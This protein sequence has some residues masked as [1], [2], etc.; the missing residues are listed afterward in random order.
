MKPVRVIMAA[1]AALTMLTFPVALA[2]ETTSGWC[3]SVWFP[4]S[5]EP[6]GLDSIR[7]HAELIDIVHPF[8]YSPLPDGTLQRHDGAEDIETLELLREANILVIPSI[9]ASVPT[10]LASDEAMTT[11]IEVITT[12]VE[13]MDYDGIDIDY[14]G[15]PAGNRDAFSLFV[16]RLADALHA[17]NRL[18]TIAL[19]AKTNDEGTWEGPRGQDWS[20]ILPVVDI[21]NL[22]TYDYTSRNEP[23]GPIAPSH[24]MADVVG[25]A[26][27]FTSLDRIRLGIPFY[28]YSWLRGSPP[29]TTISHRSVMRWVDSFNLD[30][31]NRHADSQELLIELR[32]TGLPRQNIVLNDAAS[33]ESKLETVIGVHAN[34]GGA[35]IWGIGGEDPAVWDILSRYHTGICALRDR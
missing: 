24:W 16:E 22:M 4:S 1:C 26:S 8:W 5:S 27:R 23:P 29:A 6:D 12:L 19:H 21:A 3:T 28:G 17:N 33:V 9:F 11:H 30:P 25:Y 13:R 34:L 10:M 2:Q 14:E 18:I 32:V 31:S 20:R 15:F 7:T 35:A